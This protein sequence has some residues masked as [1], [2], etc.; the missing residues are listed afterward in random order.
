MGVGTGK[1]N[2]TTLEVYFEFMDEPDNRECEKK[3]VTLY[4]RIDR[5]FCAAWKVCLVK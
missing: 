1:N 4:K 3:Y 2:N 5:Y